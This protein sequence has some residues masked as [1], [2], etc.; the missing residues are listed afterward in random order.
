MVTTDP[1]NPT[2]SPSKTSS[3]PKKP[4]SPTKSPKSP[5]KTKITKIKPDELSKT[6]PLEDLVTKFLGLQ[7]G[8]ERIINLSPMT[9]LEIESDSGRKLIWSVKVDKDEA[10]VTVDSD[11]KTWVLKEFNLLGC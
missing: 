6:P 11:G 7:F 8:D 2:S 4:S 10:T 5:V 1:I 9:E 3:S